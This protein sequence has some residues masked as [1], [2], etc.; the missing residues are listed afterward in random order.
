MFIVVV[1]F[2]QGR[3]HPGEVLSPG[4]VACR[5]TK[6][7]PSGMWLVCPRHL[8]M[9]VR[10]KFETH[11]RLLLFPCAKNSLLSTGLFKEQIKAL[12]T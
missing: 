10:R 5:D 3:W 6:Q 4:D 11:H 8:W 12:L 7:D 9:P 2:Q 1:S